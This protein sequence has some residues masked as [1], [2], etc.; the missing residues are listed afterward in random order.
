VLVVLGLAQQH[1]LRVNNMGSPTY[2]VKTAFHIQEKILHS[3]T[4]RFGKVVVIERGN[5]FVDLVFGD[6]LNA[7]QSRYDLLMPDMPSLDYVKAM[8]V[9]LVFVPKPKKILVLGMGG[10]SLPKFYMKYAPEASLEIVDIRPSL[11]DI[12]QK[13][14]GFE[15]NTNSR[16]YEQDALE[17]LRL[18]ANTTNKYD[19]ILIDV[20]I[21]GPSDILAKPELW[22][23][24]SKSLSPMGFCLSNVWREGK[25]E[26]K[27]ADILT[28]NALNFTTVGQ[29]ETSTAQAIIFSTDL[30]SSII[31]S[32]GVILRAE[33]LEQ[34]TGL[35]LPK[36]LRN[37]RILRSN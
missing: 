36:Y 3:Q 15:L 16:F 1:R 13:H 19:L 22:E 20:Y 9:G 14:F 7:V 25:H 21:E 35:N 12:A 2:Q 10:G 6:Q 32:E 8:C 4:D 18:A 30:P 27:Y 29:T 33:S 5:R 24:A 34:T 28:M 11:F 17:Y 37:T 26:V 23:Y 31:D